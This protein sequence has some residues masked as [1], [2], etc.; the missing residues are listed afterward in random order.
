MNQGRCD[1]RG[2]DRSRGRMDDNSRRELRRKK[3]Y[4]T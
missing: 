4:F 1:P 2:F 3:L